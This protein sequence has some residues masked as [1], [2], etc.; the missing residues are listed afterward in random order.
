MGITIA[1]ATK[2]ADFGR[3]CMPKTEV[4]KPMGENT[5][6]TIVRIRYSVTAL[7]SFF[8]SRTAD[9]LKSC[10]TRNILANM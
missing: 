1:N 10:S 4:T 9:A 5:S 2:S 6:E 8:A 7:R 3:I